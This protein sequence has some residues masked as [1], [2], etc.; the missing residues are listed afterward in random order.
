MSQVKIRFNTNYPLNSDKKWR[1]IVD[2]FQHLTDEVQILCGSFT[3]EDVVPDGN[4]GTVTKY[5]ISC[6]PT[7]VEITPAKAILA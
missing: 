5:H 6:N 1:V 2:G 7:K 4:G 3:S